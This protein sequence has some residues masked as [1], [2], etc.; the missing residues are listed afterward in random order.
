MIK[1]P[2]VAALAVLAGLPL[3]A[4]HAQ[5]SGAK[6]PCDQALAAYDDASHN[7]EAAKFAIDRATQLL[8]SARY[9]SRV[10]KMNIDLLGRENDVTTALHP[11]VAAIG[12]AYAA[13]ASLRETCGA[14]AALK[15]MSRLQRSAQ[16]KLK[17][18]DDISELLRIGI[19]RLADDQMADI[20]KMFDSMKVDAK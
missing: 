3:P 13:I 10:G 19:D 8:A 15:Q 5:E 7:Y 6:R 2:L 20:K 4:A 18:D 12:P 14:D 11:Y 17:V 9:S 16:F 1:S